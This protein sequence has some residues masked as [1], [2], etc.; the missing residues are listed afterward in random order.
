M[1]PEA[2]ATIIVDTAIAVHRTLGP[3]LLESAYQKCFAHA[4]RKRGRFVETELTL[5]IVFDGQH[6]ESGFRID[7]RV[8]RCV[9]VENK[10][11]E[12]IL[13][14]HQAQLL[15]YLKLSGLHIGFLLNW[16]VKLMKDGIQRM[17][18]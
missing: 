10:S 6:I 18:L 8:D 4:L 16:N 5:P 11:V 7:T 17:V 15:T 1:D 3:G 12:H 14:V 2:T 9:L 13:P